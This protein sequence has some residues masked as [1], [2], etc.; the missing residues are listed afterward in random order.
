MPVLN[1]QNEE[2]YDQ[3][4]AEGET[5]SRFVHALMIKRCVWV[6]F[7]FKYL[8]YLQTLQDFWQLKVIYNGQGMWAE[9]AHVHFCSHMNA[10]CVVS[11]CLH[12]CLQALLNISFDLLCH[13]C[14]GRV[15]VWFCSVY[16]KWGLMY[17]CISKTSYTCAY[18]ICESSCCADVI[19]KLTDMTTCD[20]LGV[21]PA[22]NHWSIL[23]KLRFKV[24]LLLPTVMEVVIMEPHK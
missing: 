4:A 13:F 20:M 8:C 24:R 21:F 19:F 2:L 11:I 16:R 9:L 3:Y 17:L 22:G 1:I 15:L 18:V 10:V 7:I 14:W 5:I 23:H 12:S 6:C